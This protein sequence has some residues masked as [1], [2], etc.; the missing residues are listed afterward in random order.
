MIG[1]ITL[2]TLTQLIKLDFASL[3]NSGF[4]FEK[5]SINAY[6]I[7]NILAIKELTMIGTQAIVKIYGNI[8]LSN[9]Q[10]N[11]YLSVTPHLDTSTAIATAIATV[12]TG[13][14]PAVV[15]ASYAVDWLLGKPF[16][17]LFTFSY[18]VT[19]DLTAPIL[20]VINIRKQITNNVGSTITDTLNR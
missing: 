11:L 15:G 3:F 9:N 13:I 19:G 16:N 8:N 17:K 18:H 10:L 12:P 4:I 14:G 2:Q 5:L 7:N 1:I 20:N 6:L